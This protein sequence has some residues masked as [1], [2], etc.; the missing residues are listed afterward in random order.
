[1]YWLN[2]IYNNLVYD[3][4]NSKIPGIKKRQSINAKIIEKIVKYA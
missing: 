4:Y 3:G 2:S 1:V